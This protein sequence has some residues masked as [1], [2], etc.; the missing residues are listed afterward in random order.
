MRR[1]LVVSDLEDHFNTI[2]QDHPLA[3]ERFVEQARLDFE[4]LA[5]MP[6]MGPRH[7]MKHPRLKDLRFWPIKHF[8]N[9]LIFYRPIE[10]G[11]EVIRVLHGARDLPTALKGEK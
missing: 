11:I 10:N 1:P 8:N 9:F 5:R 4:A 3:A 2:A 7:P 6:D